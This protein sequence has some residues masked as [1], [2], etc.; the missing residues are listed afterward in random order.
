MSHTIVRSGSKVLFGKNDVDAAPPVNYTRA[1]CGIAV[2]HAA[3]ML[4][5]VA[6]LPRESAGI[7]GIA[8]NAEEHAKVSG[9][10]A[11]TIVLYGENWMPREDSN[12][13]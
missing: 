8:K 10:I 11:Q 4:H 6:V 5:G 12:L 1:P 9:A 7:S 13:N 3:S 2:P